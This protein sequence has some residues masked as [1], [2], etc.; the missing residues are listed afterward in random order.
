MQTRDQVLIVEPGEG[1]SLDLGGMAV[2]FKVLGDRTD[3]GLSVMEH[4]M[5]PGRMI[6]PHLHQHQDELS[7][8][9][10]G[11][12]GVRVGDRVGTAGPGSY[13]FKPRRVPHT[14]WNLGPGPARLIEIIWPAGYERFL[15]AVAELTGTVADPAD[16][17]VG[18]GELAR[19]YDVELV[20][21]WIPEL[22][23]RYPL[24]VVGEP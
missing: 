18:L 10:E 15:E 6:P 11:T 4:P 21:E 24:R 19:R 5:E 1:P 3:G 16:L 7:Y 22:K 14:F 20:P 23:E 2:Q 17:E 13:F 12:F 8:V 9:L